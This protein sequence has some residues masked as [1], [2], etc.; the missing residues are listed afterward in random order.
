LKNKTLIGLFWSFADNLLQQTVNFIVGIILARILLPEE[1]GVLGII[2]VFIAISNT[3]VNSGLSD[4][5]INKN[6]TTEKDYNTV[7]WANVVLGIFTYLLLYFIAPII[8][9]F[10]EQ[11][12]LTNL[13]RIT[14]ISVILVSFSSI[15]RTI[16]TKNIDFK[17]ITVISIISVSLS[18]IIAVYMALNGYGILSLVIRIVL[19]QLFSLLLFWVLNNWRPKFIFDFE[20]FKRMYKYGVNLFLS[21]LMNSIYDNLY[22]FIIGK[23]FSPA[24]L[25]YYTRAESFKNLVSTNIINTVQR[26]SFSVLSAKNED[27]AQMDLFKKF[28]SGT[29]FITSFFMSILFVSANE[30]I[31]ILIGAKWSTSIL[32][33]KILSI[34]GLFMPLYTLNI[35]FLAVKN[36]TKL[37]FK[38]E[39]FTKLFAIPTILIGISFGIIAMLVAISIISFLAYLISVFFVNKLFDFDYKNQLLLVFKGLLLFTI[40]VIL[41]EAISQIGISNFYIKILFD[42]III[43]FVFLV[44]SQILFKELITELKRIKDNFKN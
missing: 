43:C 11:E 28:L 39:F 23:F 13:I 37:Y 9:I 17:T 36:K 27:K 5:L 26:V 29:F 35:N 14:A 19:G 24:N 2:S 8:A 21:R 41:T 3:F 30:I 25:G 12:S 34:S 16:L 18:G 31:L 4:A 10:F 22:Y 15:Q 40:S 20:S 7:F 44:G 1:F 6:E 32:Y 33:L 38:I 42:I